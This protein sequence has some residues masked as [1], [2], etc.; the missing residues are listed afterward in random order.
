MER[1][2]IWA[3]TCV[4]CPM[5]I[6]LGPGKDVRVW[7]WS[8]LLPK[9]WPTALFHRHERTNCLTSLPSKRVSCLLFKSRFSLFS[10]GKAASLLVSWSLGTRRQ[11]KNKSSLFQTKPKVSLSFLFWHTRNKRQRLAKTRKRTHRFI[12]RPTQSAYPDARYL[13]T[14]W[15]GDTQ[16]KRVP[17]F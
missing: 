14:P 1:V 12:Y 13:S 9:D 5:A 2:N 17:S 4:T 3:S 8:A 16:F 6:E 15:N 7:N 10:I 11:S